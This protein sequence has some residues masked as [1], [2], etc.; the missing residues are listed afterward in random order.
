MLEH[1][2][3]D[4]WH[5]NS[6]MTRVNQMRGMSDEAFGNFLRCLYHAQDIS[7]ASGF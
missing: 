2:H 7:R 6:M 1:V 3:V 4:L 5:V